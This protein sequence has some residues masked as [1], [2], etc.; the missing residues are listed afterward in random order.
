MTR[1]REPDPA[2]RITASVIDVL[3]FAPACL[4]SVIELVRESLHDRMS[5]LFWR[6]R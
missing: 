1:N 3:D 2:I 4:I 6:T 5:L